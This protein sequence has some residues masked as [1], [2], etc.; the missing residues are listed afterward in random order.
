MMWRKQKRKPQDPTW[1][2]STWPIPRWIDSRA[3][4]VVTTEDGPESSKRNADLVYRGP[5]DTHLLQQVMARL[6]AASGGLVMTNG[7]FV[8]SEPF[9]IGSSVQAVIT[10]NQF[11]KDYP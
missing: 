4:L 1:I 7:T 2:F 8:L 9:V 10:N 5:Q 3:T 11:V 6:D